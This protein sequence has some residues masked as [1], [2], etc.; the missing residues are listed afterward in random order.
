MKR[1]NKRIDERL[2]VTKITTHCVKVSK[3]R[4]QS[5]LPPKNA[6]QA[7]II[8]DELWDINP[9]LS[10]CSQIQALTGLRYSDASWLRFDD[11]MA[12][13]GEGFVE[14]FIVI[15]QKV[16]N[17]LSHKKS[18]IEAEN[19]HI[20]A[21]A[22]KSS[23]VRI[24]INKA[25][26][27]IVTECR[28]VNP[29]SEYLFANKRSAFI[30]GQGDLISRPMSVFSAA[31]YHLLVANKLKLDFPL[32]THSWRKYYAKL[33]LDKGAN[34]VDVRD[35]LG[36]LSLNSTNSYLHTFDDALHPL[37]NKIHL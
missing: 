32:G 37:V 19:Q 24:Y 30:D 16:F 14:N 1:I 22:I 2:D 7:S 23:S 9:V 35:L 6:K 5:S 10:L 25:I 13:N 3:K 36:H 11:F 33:L 8:F 20:E 18:P 15:Q 28:I 4:K 31:R 29:D 26:R 21:E 12:K 27:K 17:M 34:V